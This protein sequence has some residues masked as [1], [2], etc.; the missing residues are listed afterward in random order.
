MKRVAFVL[1]T[2]AIVLIMTNLSSAEL[3]QFDGKWKNNQP[4][5]TGITTLNIRVRDGRVG[6]QAWTK[7]VPK[8][9]ELGKVEAY[10]YAPSASSKLVE[11]SRT[12]TAVFR[13]DSKEDLMVIQQLG[14]NRL[15]VQ[16]F[17]RFIG[18]SRHTNYTEVYAF[19]RVSDQRLS[20]PILITP[21]DG[22]VFDQTARQAILRW[23]TVPG[24]KSYTI[25]TDCYNCCKLG[26]WCA[27]LDRTWKS[28]PNLTSPS[29]TFTFVGTQPGRWRWRVWAVNSTGMEGRKSEWREFRYAR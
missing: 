29:Y 5:S 11:T 24:A 25:E 14:P 22:K 21:S 19:S 12:L 4:V 15:R 7:C 1:T 26:R 9:C 13:R 17:T 23:N 18:A 6:V 20:A 28:I 2:C 3:S 10:A 27:D 16:V 8:D